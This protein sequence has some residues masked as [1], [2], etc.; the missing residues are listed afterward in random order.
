MAAVALLMTG[1]TSAGV[2]Q[3]LKINKL[4]SILETYLFCSPL[5]DLKLRFLPREGGYYNQFH[6][7]MVNFKAIE[8]QIIIQLQREA[9]KKARHG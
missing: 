7:D 3:H 2:C 9:E 5:M 8:S 4:P 6:V 1:Q